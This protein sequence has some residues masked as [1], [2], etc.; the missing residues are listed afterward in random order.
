MKPRVSFL[1][2]RPRGVAVAVNVLSLFIIG[3]HVREPLTRRI[4]GPELRE[5]GISRSLIG[6]ERRH[7]EQREREQRIGEFSHVRLHHE[8]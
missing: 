8:L 7:G 3:D 4:G 2:Y 6:R 1:G 5:F